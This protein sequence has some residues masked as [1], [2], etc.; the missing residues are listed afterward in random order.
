MGSSPPPLFR[1]SRP[2]ALRVSVLEQ[3]VGRRCLLACSSFFSFFSFFF[4]SCFLSLFSLLSPLSSLLSPLSSL[5]SPLFSSL[6]SLPLPPSPSPLPPSPFFFPL[7]FL[8]FSLIS[9]F[10]TFPFFAL[11]SMPW[12]TSRRAGNIMDCTRSLSLFS[13]SLLRFFYSSWSVR[14]GM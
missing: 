2:A 9:F 5:L 14:L 6:F 10:L 11:I 1:A 13:S 4:L 3:C 12:V 7:S 8:S